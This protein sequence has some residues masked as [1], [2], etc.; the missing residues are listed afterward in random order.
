MISV[1]CSESKTSSPDDTGQSEPF[2]VY[3][4]TPQ[5]QAVDVSI[6]SKISVIF[7]KSI[8]QETL[9]IFTFKVFD[10][11]E[12]VTGTISLND[13]GGIF[14]PSDNLSFGM[15]YTVTIDS[16]VKDID[17]NML[18][19]DY[20]WSFTTSIIPDTLAP[21]VSEVTPTDNATDI[22]ANIELSIKFSEQM[23]TAT[24]TVNSTSTNC[25][26][27]IQLSP[28]NFSSCVQMTEPTTKDS[29]TYKINPAANLEYA[30]SYKWKITTGAQDLAGN[31]L[32]SDN[33]YSFSTVSQPYIISV[34][35][36]DLSSD[37]LVTTSISVTFDREMDPSSITAN[38][39]T[40]TCSG[41]IQLSV[42]NFESCFKM[43][44][45]PS[46][47]G[48]NITF[49]VQSSRALNYLTYYE[50]KVTTDAQGIHQNPIISES[51]TGFTTT[52]DNFY[53]YITYISPQDGAF[54]IADVPTIALTFDQVMEPTTISANFTNTTCAGYTI[55]VSQD[56]FS[57]CVQ[58]ASA[59]VTTD[60]KKFKVV[61]SSPL[62]I[63]V[64][65]TYTVKI[66]DAAGDPDGNFLE[67]PETLFTFITT[68]NMSDATDILISELGE[69]F[70]GLGPCDFIE[71][72]N[73]T[74]YPANLSGTS[75]QRGT[76]N[77]GTVTVIELNSIIPAKGFY[78][79]GDEDCGSYGV[80]PDKTFQSVYINDDDVV[81]L[82]D[83]TTEA[84]SC[85]DTDIIDKVGFGANTCNEA[86]S[87]EYDIIAK[88]SLE[89]KSDIG[90]S[91]GSLAP[92]GNKVVAG[93]GY[94][95]QNNFNDFVLQSFPNPQNSESPTEP[96]TITGDSN[97]KIASFNIQNFG[98]TKSGRAAVI[99]KIAEI[100]IRYDL[101]FVQ[102]VD[103]SQDDFCGT[104]TSED[105]TCNLLSVINTKAGGNYTITAG[106][107]SGTGGYAERYVVY[108]NTL[109]ILSVDDN[110]LADGLA[111]PEFNRPPNVVTV[112]LHPPV[113]ETFSVINIHTSPNVATEEIYSLPLVANNNESAYSEF[114]NIILGDFN[115]DGSYFSENNAWTDFF[116]Q[117][118]TVGY[119]LLIPNFVDTT[120]S[121]SS[122]TY[123]RIVVSPTLF[124]N[125]QLGSPSPYYF[126]NLCTMGDE[127]D[128]ILTEGTEGCGVP[129]YVGA[130]LP[131]DATC[132]DASKKVSD[133]YPVEFILN[134]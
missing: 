99:D 11:S 132:L 133:H 17:G 58:M 65:T 124:D 29:I 40:V 26:G 51:I 81:L 4:V 39:S 1:L 36:T 68:D 33:N 55:Q 6:N 82:V 46:P 59:P 107:A 45:Q 118:T 57:S 42:D 23:D 12:S 72:Y 87:T 61:P 52:Y 8:S 48:G 116:S 119:E 83:K 74:D 97:I 93:N 91:P 54:N 86:A 109:T 10:G 90:D 13:K 22:S 20:I 50:I 79:I 64:P 112:T 92:G 117:F 84:A 98:D 75:V 14:S 28:D 88:K 76:G 89:R 18:G 41:T 62:I 104:N 32:I 43:L 106:P 44:A 127:M 56:G 67:N 19:E 35:P 66:T 31:A 27:S 3:A 69:D 37:I 34:S 71:L 122:N 80:T 15:E 129:P 130:Y 125:V 102:E 7:N 96:P 95:S 103:I 126:D 38:T 105:V 110:G 60:S 114:D 128:A 30:A 113:S 21:N 9:N 115:A 53:P 111:S 5:D 120:V 100:A 63:A 24:I 49:A 2:A 16:G 134:F 73:P 78:L 70:G 123:D 47:S 101:M 77:L 108:W 131:C 85:S 94:D 121:V 25:S